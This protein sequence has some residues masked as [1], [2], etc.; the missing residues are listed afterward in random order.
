MVL[1]ITSNLHSVPGSENHD[2]VRNVVFGVKV[3]KLE[4]PPVKCS[5]FLL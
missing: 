4:A 2:G 5:L 1:E 3:V